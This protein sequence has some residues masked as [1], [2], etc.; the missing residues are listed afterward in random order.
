M[1]TILYKVPPSLKTKKKIILS[2]KLGGCFVGQRHFL[3]YQ[4]LKLYFSTYLRESMVGGR[5]WKES[6]SRLISTFHRDFFFLFIVQNKTTE[7]WN[8]IV[9]VRNTYDE[10]DVNFFFKKSCTMYTIPTDCFIKFRHQ[11][12]FADT[13]FHLQRGKLLFYYLSFLCLRLLTGV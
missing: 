4:V 7:V 6:I 9:E 10:T 2:Y 12:R 5:W 8:K 3:L 1:L 13:C 11:N